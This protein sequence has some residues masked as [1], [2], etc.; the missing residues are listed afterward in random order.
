MGV[1]NLSEL[2]LSGIR[3]SARAY[4]ST[5]QS[6]TLGQFIKVLFQTEVYDTN[7]EF[8]SSRFTA[9]KSGTYLIT[10]SL[11]WASTGNTAYTQLRVYK[12]GVPS[13]VLGYTPVLSG[14]DGIARGSL[15]I[16][17]NAGDYVELYG[18]S[19]QTLPTTI[20]STETYFCIDQMY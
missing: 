17:L 10:G 13:D 5:S 20:G 8:A 7:N 14:T 12:N 11:R 16:K 4:Q 15:Q 1:Q 2:S 9:A 18:Y 19:S 3:S 6:I